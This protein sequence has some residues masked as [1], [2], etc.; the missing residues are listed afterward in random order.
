MNACMFSAAQ[1]TVFTA[2]SDK[3]VPSMGYHMLC[4]WHHDRQAK[5]KSMPLGVMTLS[6]K[7]QLGIA[8]LKA[9]ASR[10]H[11]AIMMQSGRS[12]I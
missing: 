3:E 1:T 8:A 4:L 12:E 11:E 10:N 5:K 9:A 7:R 2:Q 6:P